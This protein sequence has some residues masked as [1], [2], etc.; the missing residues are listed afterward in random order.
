MSLCLSSIVVEDARYARGLA[1]V[2]LGLLPR[3]VP[4]QAATGAVAQTQH[5]GGVYVTLAKHARMVGAPIMGDTTDTYLIVFL[6][7]TN[8]GHAPVFPF[9]EREFAMLGVSGQSL[10]RTPT[11]GDEGYQTA[12]AQVAR[13]T[14]CSRTTGTLSPGQS[15]YGS[16]TFEAP[17]YQHHAT[18]VW[19]LDESATISARW[20][21]MY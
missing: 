18:L 3:L 13:P 19:T 11:C 7:V 15:I 1:L 16:I 6:R 9:G 14:L 4:A 20:T 12:L 21:I 17:R 5:I 8:R 2:A 10:K